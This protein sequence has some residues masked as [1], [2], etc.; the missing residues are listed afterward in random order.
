MPAPSLD[1]SAADL[2]AL[3]AAIR[4]GSKSFYAAGQLLPAGY[5][6]A[7]FALYGFCRSS[8]DA[9]DA[10]GAGAAAIAAL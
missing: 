7:A 4:G 3:R 2:A 5:R 1:L 6:D 10:P 9:A 8:D